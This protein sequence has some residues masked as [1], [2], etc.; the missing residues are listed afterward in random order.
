MLKPEERI[1]LLRLLS[2]PQWPHVYQHAKLMLAID[3]QRRAGRGAVSREASR[4]IRQPA[5]S[6]PIDWQSLAG[7]L[8]FLLV[9]IALAC[10]AEAC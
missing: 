8:A 6:S 5:R 10:A 4:A 1:R 3:F 7:G 9:L 2:K